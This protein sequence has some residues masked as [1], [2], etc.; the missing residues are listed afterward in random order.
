MESIV[1]TLGLGITSTGFVFSSGDLVA[2]YSHVREGGF[3][4]TCLTPDGA[5]VWQLRGLKPEDA[6]IVSQNYQHWLTA[7]APAL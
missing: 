3:A 7:E 6:R 4:I 2:C 1:E 5:R